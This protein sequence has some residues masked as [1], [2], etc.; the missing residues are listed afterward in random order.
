M[1]PREIVQELD[2]H[3]V[4]QNQAKRAVAIALRN[5]WRRQQLPEKLRTE[6]TPKNILMIG[7]TGVGKTEIARRLARLANAPFIKV[8]ATKFTEVGYVGKEVDSIIRDLVDTSVKMTRETEMEK[9]RYRAENAAEERVLDVL[10]PPRVDSVSEDPPVFA[11]ETRQ[12]F[13]KKLREGRLNDTEIE[14]DVSAA[15]MGVEIMTPPGMEEM[16]SQLQGMFQNLSTGKK[17]MR[18]MRIKEAMKVLADEEAHKLIN[19]EELKAEALENVEQNG[20]VFLDEIDKVAKR[21]EVG[22]AD[23]SRE[24]VQRDLLPLVEGCTINT[25]Y[26]MVKT[27]HILFIASGAFHVAKPSDLI[28]ELQGRLPI[29]VELKALTTDDFVRILTEP[30]ASLTEQYSALL[31]TEG[32]ELNF[33]EDGVRKVAQI[34]HDVNESTENIGARRLHTV[35]ERLLEKVSFSA[36]DENGTAVNVDADYVDK[37][38]GELVKDQDLSRYIL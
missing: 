14:I 6:V 31:A 15:P 16:A 1:T 19:E 38:I 8:E 12:K 35:M 30:D 23:V 29:R 5:R 28:P 21:S 11:N 17:K 22:G 4:G 3:I 10:L 2:K 9:V 24:G 27:D 34:A 26:G 33:A 36:P 37:N 25:K 18:K 20:I 32:V 13:R 7:P